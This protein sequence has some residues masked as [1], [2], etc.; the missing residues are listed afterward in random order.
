MSFQPMVENIQ[1][2]PPPPQKKKF[3]LR[4]FPA[5]S[6]TEIILVL[7]K[8]EEKSYTGYCGAKRQLGERIDGRHN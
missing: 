8:V 2:P 3:F 6:K 1:P 7:E 4:L 5:G